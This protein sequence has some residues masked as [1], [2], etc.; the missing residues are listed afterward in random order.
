VSRKGWGTH[1]IEVNV[2]IRGGWRVGKLAWLLGS[3]SGTAKGQ[4]RNLSAREKG[5]ERFRS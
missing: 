4:G 5:H 2:L 3:G 1:G